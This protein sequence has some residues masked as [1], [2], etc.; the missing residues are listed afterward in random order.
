MKTRT[1]FLLIL[2]N[3]LA[4]TLP[5]FAQMPESEVRKRLDFIYSGQAER[6]RIELPGLEK[7][8]PNDPGVSYLDAI[9]TT[10]GVA[11]VKKFQAIVD[12]FP[13]NEWADDALYKVY[14]YY[15]SVG[16]YKT[17]DE[18]FAQLKRDYPNSLYVVGLEQEEKP[19]AVQQAPAVEAK[20]PDT[21][22]AQ[23]A[24]QPAVSEQTQN[25]SPDTMTAS[26]PVGK[27][28]VQAGAFSDEKNAQKQ[29]DFFRT[30]GKSAI[31]TQKAIGDKT[32]FVVSIEG[33]ATEQEARSFIA[34]L[35][36]QHNIESIIVTR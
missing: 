19:A 14:Q 13:Q 7:Q 26:A 33:F 21:A 17:A 35:K 1:L 18:K 6:V 31:I 27:Y 22:M 16:L 28:A 3:I 36:S 29:V 20:T 2:A 4:G 34:E 23:P 12:Q 24:E 10:D 11:A 30:I 15:Y 5:A 32:L 9:L 25:S 8:Y